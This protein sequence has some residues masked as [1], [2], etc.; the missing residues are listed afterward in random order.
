VPSSPEDRHNLFSFDVLGYF[1]G[2]IPKS[3][4]TESVVYVGSV[5]RDRVPRHLLVVVGCTS[6][7]YPGR[8]TLKM[9]RVGIGRDQAVARHSD[10]L[11]RRV[12]TRLVQDPVSVCVLYVLARR[13]HVEVPDSV[14][15]GVFLPDKKPVLWMLKTLCAVRLAASAE[16]DRAWSRLDAYRDAHER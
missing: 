13:Q 7:L 8:P 15:V 16:V 9:T 1:V 10:R 6:L 2:N 3:A 12:F 4:V 11:P 14:A 5:G